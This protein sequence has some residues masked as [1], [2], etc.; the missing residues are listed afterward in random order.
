MMA[1]NSVLESALIAGVLLLGC[2]ASAFAAS[3]DLPIESGGNFSV[4]VKSMKQG[5]AEIRFRST[6]PQKYDFSCGSAAVA[7]LLT[8]HYGRPSSEEEVI[9][10][11]FAR[12]DKPKIQRE[13][14]SLF[15]MKLYLESK[16]F[17]ADGFEATLDQVVKFGAPGI[18]LIQ[19]NGYKHFVVLKGV[20]KDAVLLGDPARGGRIMERKEFESIWLGRIFFVIHSHKDQ[21]RFNVASHWYTRPTAVLGDAINRDSLM[22]ITLLRRPSTDF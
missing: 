17:R 3:V 9:Q 4:P 5:L 16:G 1:G 7:T 10:A 14:F 2:A 6:I 13:G 20:E 15:D 11:M 8:Y 19:D 18:V 12:G 22:G 21:A